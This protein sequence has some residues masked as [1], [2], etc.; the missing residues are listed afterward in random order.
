MIVGAVQILD[1]A[2][3]HAVFSGNVKKCSTKKMKSLD[4]PSRNLQDVSPHS[5]LEEIKQRKVL[6]LRRW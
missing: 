3:A 5:T 2:K 6:D 1:Q 4:R